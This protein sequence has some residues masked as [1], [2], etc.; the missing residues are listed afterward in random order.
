MGLRL[1]LRIGL[2]LGKG[3]LGS[4]GLLRVGN[5]GIGV[6]FGA[7]VEVGVMVWVGIVVIYNRPYFL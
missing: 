7:G 1:R 4:L 3:W 2:E 5:L 6:E